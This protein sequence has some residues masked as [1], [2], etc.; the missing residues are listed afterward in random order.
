MALILLLVLLLLIHPAGMVMAQNQ[1]G[2]GQG[3]PSPVSNRKV[4]PE[5]DPGS[6]AGVIALVGFSTAILIGWRRRK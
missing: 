5:I 2:N 6:I 3:S 1:G 4:A